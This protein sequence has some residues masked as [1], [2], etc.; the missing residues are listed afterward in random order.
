MIR[1]LII[2]TVIPSSNFSALGFKF[3]TRINVTIYDLSLAT[4]RGEYLLRMILSVFLF[5]NAHEINQQHKREPRIIFDR[6]FWVIRCLCKLK[7]SGAPFQPYF[8]LPS[9]SNL[10][11]FLRLYLKT[12]L[13]LIKTNA[14][15]HSKICP[16]HQ[17]LGRLVIYILKI[18]IKFRHIVL[19]STRKLNP[20]FFL[21]K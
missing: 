2:L 15:P 9:H 7:D 13:C 21:E 1:S 4:C 14:K 8:W 10:W 19:W 5:K 11:I 16:Y 20:N 3:K 18:L 6:F 12:N 17:L